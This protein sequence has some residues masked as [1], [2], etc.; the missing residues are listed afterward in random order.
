MRVYR[1]RVVEAG[2]ALLVGA[3]MLAVFSFVRVSGPAEF[4]PRNLKA[5]WNEKTRRVTRALAAVLAVIGIGAVTLGALSGR[6]TSTSGDEVPSAN[7]QAGNPA[8][9]VTAGR[10]HHTALVLSVVLTVAAA[11]VA[12][13]AEL[14]DRRKGPTK[15]S[16][17]LFTEN[18]WWWLAAALL[19]V[20]GL[21][22]TVR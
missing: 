22:Q 17:R 5:G 12:L 10:F 7:A 2:I 20:A 1:A 6:G 15:E 9:V 16:R 14:V 11:G 8:H 4:D 3:A 18:R 21:L 13:A 19:A